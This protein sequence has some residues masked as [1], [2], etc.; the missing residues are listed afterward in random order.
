MKPETL[1]LPLNGWSQPRAHTS[2][3]WKQILRL[4]K[5]PA[6]QSLQLDGLFLFE[7]G[8][9]W[10]EAPFFILRASTGEGSS[11]TRVPLDEAALASLDQTYEVSLVNDTPGA[12]SSLGPLVSMVAQQGYKS[13]LITPIWHKERLLGCLVGASSQRHTFTSGERSVF[14]LLASY[15]AVAVENVRLRAETAFW[16]SE[17]MSVQTVGSALVEERSLDAILSII[18]DEAVR[19]TNASD[20][21][22][23]LLEEEGDWFRVCAR[24]G[25]GVAGL[26]S[27]RLSVE[28]SLNGV[29]VRTGQPLVSHD[30]MTDPRANQARARRLNVHTVAIAPL[31][32][33]D[34]TMGTIAVHNRCDGYFSRADVDVL[35]SFAN[36]A[37]IAIDNARLFN[38][39]LVARDEIQEKAHKLQELLVQT[40]SIQEDERRRIAG[41]IHDRLVPLIVGALYEAQALAGLQKPPEVHQKQIELIQELLN[42]AIEKTR[43]AIYDL[44]PA[45]LEQIGLMPALQELISRQERT[46]GLQHHLRVHGSPYELAPSAG[47]AVYR[48][49]QG[50]LA[51]ICQHA[52][53]TLADVLIRFSPRRV[54]IVIQ[55]DGKGFDVQSVMLGPP[56]CNFGLINM[57]ERALSIGGTLQVVSGPGQ[58]TRV[59]LELPQNERFSETG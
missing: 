14:S 17:T 23:L 15:V 4:L 46:S 26:T 3:D 58:G 37:A 25:D 36:Q 49:V 41:D 35:C 2:P 57:R 13:A 43:S 21:L 55:D 59:T 9:D 48:I 11:D 1:E 53:A 40:M 5:D 54:R 42:S 27:G 51:N 39:L 45:T 34:R 29:V 30:A 28:D 56:G 8:Q 32:I 50:A 44:W 20:A 18:I 52:D 33:R 7:L 24:M 16:L 10:E 31:K 19:L 47:I 38:E 12:A 22:V 6:N